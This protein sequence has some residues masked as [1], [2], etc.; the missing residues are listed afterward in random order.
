MESSM[1]LHNDK[2]AFSDAIRITSQSFNIREI[3]V[4]KDYWV[5]YILKELS[6]SEYRNKVV[7][8]G[9]TS[10]SKAYD[11]IKR[12]SEDVDL[13]ILD[14][15]SYTGN[16]IKDL[17]RYI[18]KTITRG[19]KEI[20]IEGVTSKH[21][22]LRRAA[23]GYE[24]HSSDQLRSDDSDKVIVE[25][26]SFANPVPYESKEIESLIGKYF[27]ERGLLYN[28]ERF[29][30]R[31]FNVNT[32]APR[33]TL[34]EKLVSIIRFSYSNS[35][36]EGLEKKIRHFYDIYFLSQSDLC[37]EY[38]ESNQFIIDFENL[39]NEDIK[40]FKEPVAWPGSKLDDSPICRNLEETWKKLI[41]YYEEDLRSLVYG[42]LIGPDLILNQTKN[43]FDR[44]KR[45]Y[46]FR[47]NIKFQ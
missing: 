40:R 14:A 6:E 20:K 10:L 17:I 22:F 28:R 46:G 24:N 19:L 5:T 12:F 38:I 29:G 30:L 43:L 23:F 15:K 7:F 41:P 18:E 37:K 33:Q 31:S 2:K 27:Y 9:G 26:N 35:K 16:G 44:I 1:I 32:L 25:I 47:H 36:E 13:A 34:I 3:F 42:T 45:Q 8:K 39:Y 11:L 4:E 21:S